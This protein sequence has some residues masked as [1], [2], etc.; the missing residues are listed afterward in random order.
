[1]AVDRSE[2]STR[3]LVV[4]G[5]PGHWGSG[6]EVYVALTDFVD[7]VFAGNG[8]KL[9]QNTAVTLMSINLKWYNNLS[10][11]TRHTIKKPRLC[12]TNPPIIKIC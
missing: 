4:S 8:I 5:R 10:L 1:M 11:A 2:W 12:C 9:G 3:V 7:H 6:E